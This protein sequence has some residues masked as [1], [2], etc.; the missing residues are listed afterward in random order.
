MNLSAFSKIMKKYEKVTSRSASRSY[1][2]IVDKSYLGVS[3]EV[4]SLLESVEATFIKHFSNSNRREGMKSLRPE[5]KREKFLFYPIL[6]F[7]ASTI[8]LME[9]GK[10]IDKEQGTLYMENIFPLHRMAFELRKG[11]SWKM[12]AVISSAVATLMNTYWDIVVDWGLLQRTSKYFCLRDELLLSHKSVYYAAVV[13]DILLRFAWLQLM[14][15]F[16]LRS[17]RGKTIS[18]IIACLE[19]L[20]HGMWNLFRNT[21]YLTKLENEH[22]NNVGKYRAF[23]SV[24][25]PFNYY[26]ELHYAR[27]QYQ[28]V[29]SSWHVYGFMAYTLRSFI[30]HQ[31]LCLFKTKPTPP[32]SSSSDAPRAARIFATR[33]PVIQRAIC[34]SCTCPVLLCTAA[35]SAIVSHVYLMS[36]DVSP[37]CFRVLRLLPCYHA[38]RLSVNVRRAC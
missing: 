29:F 30:S 15:K 13:L 5:Q 31:L 3:D 11:I 22:L 7:E 17:L 27:L 37:G 8:L 25:L 23:K 26:D 12:L 33:C 19:I 2:K 36:A 4:T 18:S 10:L 24:P 32:D 9:S 34:A 21:L 28:K 20:R 6:I 38:P 35:S 1:M 16:N 14:L